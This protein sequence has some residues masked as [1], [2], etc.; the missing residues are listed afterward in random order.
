MM[1]MV[2]VMMMMMMMMMTTI[3]LKRNPLEQWSLV[4]FQSW[5]T[6][7]HATNISTSELSRSSILYE[8]DNWHCACRWWRS[9]SSATSSAAFSLFPMR[10]KRNMYLLNQFHGL[11]TIIAV[12]YPVHWFIQFGFLN[13]IIH[14]IQFNSIQL[15]PIEFHPNRFPWFAAHWPRGGVGP[16]QHFPHAWRHIESTSSA[17]RF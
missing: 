17:S 2:V 8:E 15:N 13:S 6:R 14:P 11:I 4:K 16:K 1:M 7:T 5:V 9:G 12:G 10:R 3:H